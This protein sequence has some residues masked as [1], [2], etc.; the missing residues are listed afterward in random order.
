MKYFKSKILL[1]FMGCLLFSGCSKNVETTED[2]QISSVRDT[3]TIAVFDKD[4]GRLRD[5]AVEFNDAHPEYEIEIWEY[6]GEEPED[7]VKRF[8]ADIVS[9]NLPDIIDVGSLDVESYVKQGV[10]EELSVYFEQDEEIGRDDFFDNVINAYCFENGLYAVPTTFWISS[11]IG[12]TQDLNGITGWTFQEYQTYMDGLAHPQSVLDGSS[13]M[14]FFGGLME[15]YGMSFIDM[16]SGTCSFENNDFIALLNCSMQYPEK[17]GFTDKEQEIQMIQ[18]EQISL[19]PVIINSPSS[20]LVYKTEFDDNF[21]FVGFPSQNGTGTKLVVFGAAYGI[22]KNCKH[23]NVVW[24]LFKKLITDEDI[25]LNGFP[26]YQKNMDKA[27]EFISEGNYH[28]NDNGEKIQEPILKMPY[29]DAILDI[30]GATAEDID[31]LKN[32]ITNA[33]A[34]NVRNME[35]YSILL[36]EAETFFKSSKSA[37]E[38]AEIIQRRIKLYLAEN[39]GDGE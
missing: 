17:A 20:Y 10:L 22:S 18:D 34:P 29:G 1:L 19:L 8:Q 25:A 9:G 15:Q 26:T 27:F 28:L 5:I 13:R 6:V 7:G 39:G 36:E 31:F 4:T 24:E 14:N 12:K 32:L 3:I 30:Y 23:K 37:E 2:K 38:V 16:K 21:T 11:M 35:I 33:D